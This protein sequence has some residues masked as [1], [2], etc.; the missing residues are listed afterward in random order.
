MRCTALRLPAIADQSPSLRHDFAWT[1]AG[2][3]I[4]AACQWGVVMALAKLSSAS[5]VGQFGLGMAVTAPLFLFSN[6]SLRAVLATDGG[7]QLAFRAYR[8][9]RLLTTTAAFAVALAIA[10][11]GGYRP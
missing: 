2:N 5:A 1:L 9:L 4:F 3:S 6:L 7:G 8:R 10:L 11:A